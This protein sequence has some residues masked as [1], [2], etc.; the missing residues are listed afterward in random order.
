MIPCTEIGVRCKMLAQIVP[1][2]KTNGIGIEGR[3]VGL[4]QISQMRQMGQEDQLDQANQGLNS[5]M[6]SRWNA[7]SGDSARNAGVADGAR[8]SHVWL[9]G[10]VITFSIAAL[11]ALVTANECQSITHPA[12]LV[13]GVVLWGWW[14]VIASAMWTLGKQQPLVSSFTV[15][16][17]AIHVPLAALLG[18]AHLTLLWGLGFTPLGWEGNTTPE[19]M[20][21]YLFNVN[22][23]GIEILLYGFLFAIVSV[24]QNQVRAQREAMRSLELERQLSAAQLRALQM[25]MEPHFLFNTL[26][27]ITALVEL[28]RQKEAAEMLAHLNAILKSTLKRTTPEKVPLSQ[29]LE[30]VESYLAIEQ[31]RFAERLRIEIKVEPGALDGLVPCFLLQPIVENAIRHGIANCESDGLVEASARREGDMLRLLVRDSGYGIDQRPKPG[32]GIGLSNTRE[33]L[34]H[35][36]H[37]AYDMRALPLDRGGFEVAI[38][39]PYEQNLNGIE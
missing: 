29:E 20:A 30:I 35:F 2:G 7:G 21:R 5:A 14:G 8:G 32:N 26:N 23:Y 15:K 19:T 10:H 18:A 12:S 34:A 36:Y 3:A 16:A 22:R 6:A 13:Y 4:D 9:N 27:S 11:L 1:E 25:Q 17:M 38:T 31:A 39:I 37:E 33:R 28:G 24:V